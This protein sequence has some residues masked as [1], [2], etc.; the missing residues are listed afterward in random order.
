MFLFGGAKSGKSALIKVITSQT[1]LMH[2]V[3]S[4]TS[5]VPLAL[6]HFRRRPFS[7]DIYQECSAAAQTLFKFGF[8][9]SIVL[10]DGLQSW[11]ASLLIL[12][13]NIPNEI[14]K[15]CEAICALKSVVIV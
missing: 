9:Y 2:L 15:L 6:Q 1:S 4:P 5:A 7:Y 13:F 11:I 12:K 8:N 14:D 10:I 3:L